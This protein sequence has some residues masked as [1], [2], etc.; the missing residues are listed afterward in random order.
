MCVGFTLW[1]SSDRQHFTIMPQCHWVSLA[2]LQSHVDFWQEN[3]AQSLSTLR[4]TN[5]RRTFENI[6]NSHFNRTFIPSTMWLSH[7]TRVFTFDRSSHRAHY[8]SPIESAHDRGRGMPA[9][10]GALWLLCFLAGLDATQKYCYAG[11][12]IAVTAGIIL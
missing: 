5:V 4:S 2:A 10:C 8:L 11:Q 7:I 9:F 12:T 6:Q 3:M 1:P